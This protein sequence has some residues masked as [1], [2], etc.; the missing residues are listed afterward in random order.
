MN[1]IDGTRGHVVV[2]GGDNTQLLIEPTI[3]Q[4]VA[5]NDLLMEKELF[6]PILAV[7]PVE[8]IDEAIA[9]I[10]ERPHALM[11][12]VFTD[13]DV[14]KQKVLENTQSGNIA[15]NDTFQALSVD[16]LPFGGVGESGYGRQVLKYTFDEFTY[17]RSSIDMPKEAEPTLEARYPPYNEEKLQ[18]LQV[19]C[20][21]KIPDDD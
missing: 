18:F 10:N 2:G 8:N 5:N 15:F 13:D 17:L 12:Y 21:T 11:L 1:L 14:I 20:H 6:G 9:F 7:I 16:A 4:N 19:A 3:V